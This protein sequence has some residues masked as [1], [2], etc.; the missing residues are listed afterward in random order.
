MNKAVLVTAIVIIIL[1]ISSVAFLAARFG[2][3]E[4]L[5][6]PVSPEPELYMQV[7][8]SLQE[9][10][11]NLDDRPVANYSLSIEVGNTGDAESDWAS[12]DLTIKRNDYVIENEVITIGIIVE[13]DVKNTSRQFELTDGNYETGLELKTSSTVWDTFT[14]SFV[15]GFPRQGFGDYVRFYVT[16]NDHSVQSHLETIGNDVNTLYGWVG[17]NIQYTYDSDVYGVEEYWQFPYETL[18]LG[19]GDCEDQAFLLCS[20]IRASGTSAENVFVALGKVDGGHAWVILKTE[21]GWRTFEPTTEGIIERILTDLAE[22][23][24]LIEREYYSASNDLYFEEIDPSN[25]QPYVSQSFQGWY[26]DNVKLQGNRVTVEV[27]RTV[28]LKIKVTNLGSY[29]FIGFIMIEIKKDIVWGGDAILTTHRYSTTLEA[30]ESMQLEPSFIPDEVTQDVLW[31]CKHYYYK[32]YTCFA[33][34]YNPTDA[35]TRECLFVSS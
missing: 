15:V 17:D 30:G 22:F 34:I 19:T 9:W 24:G 28:I 25:N 18:N 5:R 2:Y 4:E 1:A 26:E 32:V 8:R 6:E 31:K 7:H 21:G 27:N 33:C 29:D 20:L 11:R 12:I 14:D 10:Y 3:F 16:P 35:N 23:F 13:G